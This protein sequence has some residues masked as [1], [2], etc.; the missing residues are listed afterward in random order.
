MKYITIYLI[1]VIID[2]FAYYKISKTFD[3]FVL[4][5]PEDRYNRRRKIIKLIIYGIL[6]AASSVYLIYY[7]IIIRR[8]VV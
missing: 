4:I 8:G 7:L 2:I 6:Y 3:D 5:H 1:C